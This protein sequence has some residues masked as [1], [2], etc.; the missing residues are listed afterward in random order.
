MVDFKKL[1]DEGQASAT[2]RQPRSHVSI[3]NSGTGV[4]PGDPVIDVSPNYVVYGVNSSSGTTFTVYDKT[5]TKLSGPTTF[6]SLA[7]A[8]DG[9]GGGTAGE[10]RVVGV[11]IHP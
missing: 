8:G 4:S 7:P 11:V 1:W 5:G 3:N 2:A 9:G 10:E 6:S